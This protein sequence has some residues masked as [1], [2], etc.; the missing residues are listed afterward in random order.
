MP[1]GKLGI[2]VETASVSWWSFNEQGLG[3]LLIGPGRG[4]KVTYTNAQRARIVAELQRPPDRKEDQTAT[5]SLMLLRGA[6]RKTELPHIAKET[7]RVVLHE[8]GYGF[9]KTRTWCPTG[10]A[11]RVRKAGTVKVEDPKGPEKKG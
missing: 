8:A 10:T 6:V 5:W 2:K 9:G 11:L 1:P 3:A 4:R 7:I